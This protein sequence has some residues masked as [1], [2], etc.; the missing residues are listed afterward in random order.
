MA[1]KRICFQ[2][3]GEVPIENDAGELRYLVFGD[4]TGLQC[5]QR[6]L[7]L[8]P[9]VTKDENDVEV[10]V[11]KGSPHVAQYLSGQPRDGRG[12]IYFEFLE[13]RIRTAYQQLQ[14][15]AKKIE[16]KNNPPNEKV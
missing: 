16:E 4:P 5:G 15:M 3:H 14:V 11:C 8:L 9:V 13:V 10:V 6:T 12:Y 2:C 7:H 1:R